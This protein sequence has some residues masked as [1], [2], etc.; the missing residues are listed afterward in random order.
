M[1]LWML[2]AARDG[3]EILVMSRIRDQVEQAVVNCT[4]CFGGA[5]GALLGYCLASCLCWYWMPIGIL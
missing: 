3:A 2:A 1:P 4:A 5:S